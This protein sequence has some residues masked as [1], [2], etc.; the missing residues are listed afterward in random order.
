MSKNKKWF[1]P[2]R[3]SYLPCSW[4]GWLLYVPYISWM[5]LTYLRIDTYTSNSVDTLIGIV[6]FWISASVVLHWI[7]S[8]RS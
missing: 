4:Q 6:P 1:T 3:G 7:A 2:V 5:V 8:R